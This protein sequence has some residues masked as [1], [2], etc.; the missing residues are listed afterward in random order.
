MCS[1]TESPFFMCFKGK[2]FFLASSSVINQK[3]M[4]DSEV[5]REIDV[6][7]FDFQSKCVLQQSLL[8]SPEL[9]ENT[10]LMV[11]RKL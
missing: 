3:G 9:H 5:S 10:Y 7:C 8:R 4:L 6:N 11:G 2:T 1:S